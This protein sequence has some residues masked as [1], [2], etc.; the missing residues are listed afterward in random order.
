MNINRNFDR[1]L[2]FFYDGYP[3]IVKRYYFF[4]LFFLNLHGFKRRLPASM[5][6]R[7]TDEVN[8]IPT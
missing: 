6:N 5:N 2:I 8:A 7:N 4:F 3:R 1:D